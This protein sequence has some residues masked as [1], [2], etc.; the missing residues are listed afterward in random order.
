MGE[1]QDEIL[2]AFARIVTQQG[3]NNTTMRDVAREVGCS[4]GTLYNEFANKEALIY[5]LYQHAQT[6]TDSLLADLSVFC[7]APPEMRLRRFVIGFIREINVRIREDRIFAE[8][9][10][11]GCHFRYIGMKSLEFRQAVKGK[12]IDILAEILAKGVEGGTFHLANIP[13][14]AQLVMEA[15]SAYLTPALVL[16]REIEAILQDAEAM[17]DLVIRAL[18][19]SG[20]H[21]MDGGI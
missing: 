20:N 4:V 1:R 14:A 9:L 11:D 18:K 13:L 19:C 15:F 3:I 12:V 10:K 17:L 21:D 7:K 2:D 8:F 16:D 6:T 5:G